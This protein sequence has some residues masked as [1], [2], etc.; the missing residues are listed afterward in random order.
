MKNI[1]RI[2]IIT[3]A[4]LSAI[5]IAGCVPPNG[6]YY[7]SSYG[8][9]SSYDSSYDPYPS[10]RSDDYDYHR[11]RE[12][13]RERRE[14][15]RR[16]RERREMRDEQRRQDEERRRVEDERRRDEERM[17]RE[18]QSQS[19]EPGWQRRSSKCSNDERKHGCHDKH[20][21]NGDTCVRF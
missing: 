1:F 6:N 13:E 18:Q 19:C 10:R 21:P 15:E 3:I 7:P 9:P 14:D 2:K 4:G 20:A 5:A 12:Y 17:R 11:Q 16:D 8:S